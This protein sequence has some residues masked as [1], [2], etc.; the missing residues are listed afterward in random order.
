MAQR[1]GLV[2]RARGAGHMKVTSRDG[3]SIDNAVIAPVLAEFFND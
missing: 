1:V 3:T 2:A